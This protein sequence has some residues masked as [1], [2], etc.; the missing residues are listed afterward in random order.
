[1]SSHKHFL[2]VIVLGESGVGKTSLM[3]RF[4]DKKYT[5]VYKAT[6]GADFLSKD[7][8]VGGRAVSLQ[9]W[10]TGM[11]SVLSFILFSCEL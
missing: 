5:G 8:N 9:V 6:I 4:M 3:L 10:D 7:L 2:K 1:M 11:R